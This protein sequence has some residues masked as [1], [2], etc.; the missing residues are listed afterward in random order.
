LKIEDKQ[1]YKNVKKKLPHQKK[2]LDK[3]KN[4]L[5]EAEIVIAEGKEEYW[6]GITT[7]FEFA[8][9]MRESKELVNDLKEV[10][11]NYSSHIDTTEDFI[12]LYEDSNE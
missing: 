1:L 11:K 3:F 10:I 5:K 12:Y 9:F 2:V 7:E 6:Q 8:G 4:M